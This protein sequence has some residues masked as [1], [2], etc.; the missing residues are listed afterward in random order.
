MGPRVRIDTFTWRAN[1]KCW[2][3]AG[4]GLPR[5][6][7]HILWFPDAEVASSCYMESD[8]DF[9]MIQEVAKKHPTRGDYIGSL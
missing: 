5:K 9:E 7:D 4:D 3:G 2:G 8:Q 1:R 6:I